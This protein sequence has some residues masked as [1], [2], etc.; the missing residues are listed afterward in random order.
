MQLPPNTSIIK[1]TAVRKEVR[2]VQVRRV[3]VRR[4]QV[5]RV[6]VRK[7][8]QASVAKPLGRPELCQSMQHS[9]NVTSQF[10]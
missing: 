1:R 9:I 7:E 2:R 10:P 6:Q 8:P 3:Q 5:R 4:V